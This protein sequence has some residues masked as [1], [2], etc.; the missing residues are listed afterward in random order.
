MIAR[1]WT[2]DNI[3]S[4]TLLI[5]CAVAWGQLENTSFYGA[6]FPKVVIALLAFFT[7]INLLQGIRKPEKV[8][9]FEGERK[10]Y[11]FIMLL[12]MLAYVWLIS[13]IG[14]LLSSIVFMTVFFWFLGDE[15]SFKNAV[16]SIIF[17]VFLSTVFSYIF[18]NIFSVTLPR[19]ILGF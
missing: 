13:R 9:I 3:F 11:I 14:F 1:V 7:I 18:V 17:A 19:G 8:T 2:N 15:R 10:I 5:V 16:K 4:I 6:L 12:G